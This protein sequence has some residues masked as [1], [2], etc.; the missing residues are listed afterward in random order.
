MLWLRYVLIAFA[1]GLVSVISLLIYKYR[2]MLRKKETEMGKED[3]IGRLFLRKLKKIE[4]LT[5]KEDPSELFK[6]LNK[7]MRGFF[8]EL[9]DIRYEFDYVELNEELSK[10]GVK[11]DIRH[12]VISY[13]MGMS[14]AEYGGRKITNTDFY[15]LLG[16]SSRIITKI[17]GQEL[18]LA[19]EKIPG[20]IPPEK[21]VA[22]E[23]PKEIPPEKEVAEEIPREIPP[24]MEEKAPEKEI[25]EE[26]PK[27]IPPEKEVAEEIPREI[28]PEMEEKA[29]EKEIIEEVP[30]EKP[31]ERVEVKPPEKASEKKE[32]PEEEKPEVPEEYE[33]AIEQ[34]MI[35]PPDEQ[36]RMQKL[37]KMLLE[38]EENVKENRYEDAMESYSELRKIY[39]S[40]SPKVKLG[41]YSETER[42]IRIYNTLLKEYKDTLT[43][44]E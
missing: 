7:T 16:K 38:A 30:K 26:V 8:S 44:K 14:R 27:E 10:Q 4:D 28:P 23:V 12:E 32:I 2:K 42:I 24:E 25:I 5:G 34:E 41:I 37:R 33:K 3:V 11:E 9:F 29:P 40:L 36:E 21:E 31:P 39:D 19:P 6:K 15:S 18:E 20:K 22:E 1:A 17:T 13:T 35:V 43:G